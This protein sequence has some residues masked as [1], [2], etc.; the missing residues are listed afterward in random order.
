MRIDP[1]GTSRTE[2]S[3]DSIGAWLRENITQGAI[4]SYVGPILV[5]GGYA[6]LI[7]KSDIYIIK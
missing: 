7:R 2:P 1:M 4:A 3:P 5:L 6:R